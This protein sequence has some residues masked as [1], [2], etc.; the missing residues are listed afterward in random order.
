M[1]R[2]IIIAEAGVN[3]NGSVEAAHKLIDIAK[4][5]GADAIKF[6]T[7][8]S[9]L[10]LR[11]DTPL[12]DYQRATGAVT[13]FDLVKKLELT[14]EEFSQLN[15]H[16]A[17]IG[18]EFMS[19]AFD[20][21][22]LDFLCDE[23]AMG[24]I[25]IPSG[26]VV[27][28]PLLRRAAEKARPVIL[29]TGMCT[30][31]EIGFALNTMRASSPSD[32]MDTT[33]MHCTTAYPTPM[34]E[35]H[36]RAMTTLRDTFGLPVGLSDHSEGFLAAAA[37]VAMGG[38]MIEKHFTLDRNLPGPDHKASVDPDGLRQFVE[39]V[40]SVERMMGS[41]EKG[42]RAIEKDTIRLVRRSLVA[43]RDIAAGEMIGESD[44]VALRP[45]DGI[46]VREIDKVVGKP[47]WQAFRRG[48]ALKWPAA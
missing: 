46:P 39:T 36:L 5:C 9:E 7:F 45:E 40:R 2:V 13:M 34:D 12:V 6:Q 29:S 24:R 32:V 16:C 33:V 4:E 41:A 42:L 15:D 31:E 27:N 44:L 19:T 25:K 23:L 21:P 10:V 48:E 20:L 1:S 43:T 28:V 47:S 37:A 38:V 18:I 3:H 8:S 30:L 17:R 26:E 11:R 35:I 22:S 14:R